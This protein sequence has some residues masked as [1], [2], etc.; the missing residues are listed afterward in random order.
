MIIPQWEEHMA[1]SSSSSE[2]FLNLVQ[3]ETQEDPGPG[4]AMGGESM[5]SIQDLGFLEG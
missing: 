4:D 1:A 2:A 5:A 3:R